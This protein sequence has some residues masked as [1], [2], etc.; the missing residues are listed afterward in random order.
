RP[1]A[2]G[3][4]L[5]LG[6]AALVRSYTAYGTWRAEGDGCWIAGRESR[7]QLPLVEPAR[8]SLV[9]D[10]SADGFL[11]PGCPRQRL[12]VAV[13]GHR[14]SE[15]VIEHGSELRDEPI[16][17]PREAVAGRGRLDLVLRT[18]DA[19]SPA[20]LGIDDDDR[21]IGVF[22]RRAR[23][24]APSAWE[25]G[26]RLMLGE[27]FDDASMLFDGWAGPEQRGR[28]MVGRRARLLMRLSRTLPALDLEMEAAP[29]LGPLPRKLTVELYINDQRV[30]SVDYEG[31]DEDPLKP[32]MTRLAL[33]AGTVRDDGDVLIE[34]RI[35]DPRS[36]SSLGL[37]DDS[38]ELG[39]FLVGLAVLERKPVG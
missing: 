20:R 38:R 11:A 36:P 34:W 35:G 27:G 23:V 22:V 2:L 12:R 19:S 10:L 13:N 15:L 29:F 6:D 1:V 32:S 4:L 16:V 39:L 5:D 24:R 33:P 14:V 28:W 25:P 17:L 30:G 37:S 9:L 26:S 21:R 8:G 7:L 3:E 31:V 18:P